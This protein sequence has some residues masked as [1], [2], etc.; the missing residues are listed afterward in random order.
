MKNSSIKNLFMKFVSVLHVFRHAVFAAVLLAI[1]L[2]GFALGGGQADSSNEVIIWTYDSFNSDWGPGPDVVRAFEEATGIRAVF[3][4]HSDAGSMVSRLLLEGENA[5]ADIVLGIDQNLAPRVLNTNLFEAY[6]P[7]GAENI[8][9]ELIFDPT[10]HLIPFDYSFFAIN[11]DSS[12]LSNPPV[13]LE[14][15]T[16][17]RFANSLILLDPR[18]SSPGLGFFAW[19][20]EIYGAGW[21]D[22]W[23]RLQP[24]ILTIAS[25]WSSG[26]GLYTRGEAPLVL[27]YTT[28]PAYHIEYEDTDR[29]R[30]A[31]FTDGHPMQIEVAGLLRN[32]PNRNNARVFLDFMIS[33]AFQSIIPLTNWMYPVIDIPLP[34]SFLANPKSDRPLPHGIISESILNEWAAMMMR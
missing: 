22:Y 29:F 3:V 23:Q 34:A 24:S 16:H 13:S 18:T 15:L 28:S 33:P 30:A 9:P 7:R 8:F 14:D 25:S 12:R 32:A 11:Y 2:P 1:A 21:L 26:Y 6:T 4:N 27:S 19:V 20:L 5:N 17:P 10:F 31:I